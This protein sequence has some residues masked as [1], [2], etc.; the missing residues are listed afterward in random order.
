MVAKSTVIIG[1]KAPAGFLLQVGIQRTQEV[2]GK[3]M[4]LNLRTSGYQ[5][6]RIFGWNHHNKTGLQMP[7]GYDQR[8]YLNRGVP[9]DFWEKWKA[10]NPG[11][12]LLK[13]EILFEAA[14]EAS[15]TLRQLE[16]DHTPRILAP[17]EVAKD[18]KVTNPNAQAKM[19]IQT[20]DFEPNKPASV[21][22]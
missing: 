11:I 12:W 13:N 1:C 19:E 14:D 16:G 22:T 6:W 10:E 18:G 4:P 8:P 9:K 15:A 17:I 3:K 21:R 20:A 5:E 7:A 2:D